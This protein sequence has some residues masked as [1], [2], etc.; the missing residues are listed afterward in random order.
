[1]IAPSALEMVFLPRLAIRSQGEEVPPLD[2]PARCR[3]RLLKL[4]PRRRCSVH[5]GSSPLL[6]NDFTFRRTMFGHPSSRQWKKTK[7]LVP[8][9]MRD[10]CGLRPVTGSAT[11]IA[12]SAGLAMSSAPQPAQGVFG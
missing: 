11:T 1:M 9:G 6:T 4:S 7:L 8:A 10:G 2:H 3:Q 5:V 12:A